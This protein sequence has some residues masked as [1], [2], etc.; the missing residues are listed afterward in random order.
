MRILTGP[1]DGGIR[2]VCEEKKM[3][4]LAL[5]ENVDFSLLPSMRWTDWLAACGLLGMLAAL[6]G[7]TVLVVA[8]VKAARKRGG[9]PGT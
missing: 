3:S 1:S 5:L 2:V 9:V 7:P 8:I 6:L 4:A